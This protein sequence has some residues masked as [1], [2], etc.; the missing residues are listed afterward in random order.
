MTVNVIDVLVVVVVRFID[1][2]KLGSICNHKKCQN[3]K[4]DALQI[5]R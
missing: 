1:V 3:H 2:T 4:N 5:T